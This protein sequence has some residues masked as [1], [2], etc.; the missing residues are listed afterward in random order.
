M[1]TR[2]KI[3]G[4][5]I[6]PSAEDV[7]IHEMFEAGVNGIIDRS[8]NPRNAAMLRLSMGTASN[9]EIAEEDAQSFHL[10]KPVGPR[11]VTEKVRHA[12]SDMHRL[13]RRELLNL[14]GLLG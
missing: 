1:A 12:R 5:L 11:T 7:V 9:A 3:D 13:H 4:G 6:V 10:P 14:K 2:S 8:L